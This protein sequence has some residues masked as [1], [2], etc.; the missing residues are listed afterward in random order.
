MTGAD[1]WS[2]ASLAFFAFGVGVMAHALSPNVGWAFIGLALAVLAESVAGMHRA[3][4]VPK[5]EPVGKTTGRVTMGP[6]EIR[7]AGW[8]TFPSR[9]TVFGPA[10]A[11]NYIPEPEE[12]DGD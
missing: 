1:R 3:K 8:K 5:S 6:L 11:V 12:P 7:V 4:P 9:V 10:G 2:C